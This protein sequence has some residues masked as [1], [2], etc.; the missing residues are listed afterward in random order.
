[1]FQPGIGDFYF[2]L[3][4]NSCAFAHP[5]NLQHANTNCVNDS[6]DGLGAAFS[7]AVP[8]HDADARD[9]TGIAN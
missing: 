8:I 6:Y 7:I 1:M 3:S 9:R 4:G 2:K 5:A